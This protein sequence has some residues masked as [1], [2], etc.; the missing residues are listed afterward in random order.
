MSTAAPK[1]RV[2]LALW[3]EVAHQEVFAQ[4]AQDCIEQVG[5]RG[6]SAHNIHLTL[7]F[8]GELR[9]A[10][11]DAVSEVVDAV[12]IEPFTLRFDRVGYWPRNR[13]VWAGCSEVPEPL[14]VLV[15]TL[16]TGLRQL[17]F[18]IDTRPYAPHAT[19]V[20]K[21]RRRPRLEPE[22]LVWPVHSVV[23]VR[24]ELAPDGAHYEV[25]RR[26]SA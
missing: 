25:I 14:P 13:I 19:L 1:Q 5:G 8:L 26:W 3:P 17:G 6:I 15:R 4:W 23:L 20:R 24:S 11:V 2:F 16:Q 12:T 10:Q 18:R 22:P 7:A 21:A 9:Q